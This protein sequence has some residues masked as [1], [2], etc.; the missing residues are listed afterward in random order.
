[1]GNKII[2][3]NK[4]G[5]L[6]VLP[7][8]VILVSGCI[9]GSSEQAQ[10]IFQSALNRSQAV[11]SYTT[12]YLVNL[13]MDMSSLQTGTISIMSMDGTFDVWKKLDKVKMF[14]IVNIGFFGQQQQ[15]SMYVFNLPGGLYVCA[16][17][18]ESCELSDETGLPIDIS[19]PDESLTQLQ[20]MINQGI[21]SL[22][23]LGP[24][25]VAGRMCENVKAIVDVNRLDQIADVPEEFTSPEVQEAIQSMNFYYTICLD[26]ATGLSL[27]FLMHMD[28][29]MVSEGQTVSM[30]MDFLTS[31]TSFNPNADV[32]DSEFVLPYEVS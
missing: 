5:L 10:E 7:V 2:T 20:Y 28:M 6:L 13:D 21:V 32:L 16:D 18:T 26:Q 29:V 11:T 23:Y 24:K 4:L 27:E 8:F 14:G 9:E 12:T 31:A 17:E 25:T 1:M 22:A 30:A 15:G 3:M 19:A